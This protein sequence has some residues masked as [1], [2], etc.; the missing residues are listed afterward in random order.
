MKQYFRHGIIGAAQKKT[1]QFYLDGD[2]EFVVSIRSSS[3]G[4]HVIAMAV[5]IVLFAYINGP[6]STI[7]LLE[8]DA[9]MCWYRQTFCS[10]TRPNW[11]TS[12]GIDSW[13]IPIYQ[14]DKH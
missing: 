4:Q 9:R 1:T 14:N 3:F 5:E 12:P 13:Y 6:S 2:V 8:N 7:F 10:E 11:C